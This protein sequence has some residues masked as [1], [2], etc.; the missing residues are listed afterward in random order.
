[1]WS[2]NRAAVFWSCTHSKTPGGS[3][4]EIDR[5]DGD[6]CWVSWAWGA[7]GSLT[8]WIEDVCFDDAMVQVKCYSITL[9]TSLLISSTCPP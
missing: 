5:H 6:A 9:Y 2:V 7:V 8:D 1:M 3:G 4:D